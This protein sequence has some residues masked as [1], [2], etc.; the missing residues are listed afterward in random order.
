MIARLAWLSGFLRY[1]GLIPE[2][3]SY[4]LQTV[5]SVLGVCDMYVCNMYTRYR[6]NRNVGQQE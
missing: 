5:V 2:P 1:T 4:D 6:K 3:N